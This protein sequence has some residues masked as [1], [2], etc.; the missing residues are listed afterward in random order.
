MEV[1][2]I[3]HSLGLRVCEQPGFIDGIGIPRE[4]IHRNIPVILKCASL[5]HD[6][7][8]PP[9]G[10]FGETVIADYFKNYFKKHP[11]ILAENSLEKEDFTSF[12]GNAQGL[13]VL[14]KLQLLNDLYGLNLTYATLGAYLKYPN[15]GKIDKSKIYSKKRG[16]FQ[17]ESDYLKKISVNCNM[18]QGESIIRHP[19]S[20][21]MEAADSICYLVMD[22]EDGFNKGWYSYDF[23]KS[24]I[25]HIDPIRSKFNDLAE[26]RNDHKDVARM[27]KLRIFLIAKLVELAVTNFVKN[28]EIICNGDYNKELIED[29]NSGLTKSLQ[30]FCYENIFN[31]REIQQLEL[32]GHS[33]ITGL[34]DYYTHC[35]FDGSKKYKQRAEGMISGSIIRTALLENSAN[36]FDDLNDYFKLRVIVDFISGMTDQFALDH[37]QKLSGQKIR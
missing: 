27:V 6:I 11:E 19:L 35:L 12:D 4:D 32:T 33:V 37:F 34:L 17:S 36:N 5:V 3:G 21:L 25:E 31:R 23:I 14:T 1:M 30:Q 2:A 20:F 16:V 22:I 9:F 15:A 8:N 7:G 13:R 29:D 24:K 18:N 26:V 10:H 28:L